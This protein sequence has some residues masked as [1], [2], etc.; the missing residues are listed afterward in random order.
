MAVVAWEGAG[1]RCL[2]FHP[3]DGKLRYGD[4]RKVVEGGT[5]SYTDKMPPHICRRGMHASI[6]FLDA[7]MHA[8]GPILCRVNVKGNVSFGE[9]KLCG[10]D[11]KCLKVYGDVRPQLI[12]AVVAG[13]KDDHVNG[14]L[15]CQDN[16]KILDLF[17]AAMMVGKDQ[18]AL[19]SYLEANPYF[20]GDSRLG[21]LLD[22][23]GC[24][25]GKPHMMSDACFMETVASLYDSF[26]ETGMEAFF[27]SLENDGIQ[28]LR[29]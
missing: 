29:G 13:L 25:S 28:G 17:N 12:R 2:A 5:L 15:C 7:L 22:L 14:N 3:A 8:P 24:C 27:A 20:S 18:A 9:D 26:E 16:Q 4:A 21:C 10:R 1:F 19:A 11:R 6:R 23:M